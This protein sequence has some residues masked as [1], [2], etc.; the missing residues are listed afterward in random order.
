MA[1]E[2]VHIEG[3]ETPEARD[4]RDRLAAWNIRQ[5]GIGDWQPMTIVLRD[6]TGAARG[7]VLGS[8]WAGGLCT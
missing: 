8:T 7:G 6:D 5:T 3:E 2:L 1:L 4:I